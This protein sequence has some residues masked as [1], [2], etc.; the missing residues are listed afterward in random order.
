MGKELCLRLQ[1]LDTPGSSHSSLEHEEVKHRIKKALSQQF[2][3]GL[4]MAL[5]VLRA[6]IPFC[7]E[8]NQYTVKLAE[9]LLGPTWNDFTTVIFTHG[10]KLSETCMKEDEYLMSAP[11]KLLTLLE[12]VHKKYIFRDPSDKSLQKERAIL[13]SQMFDYVKNNKYQ[14]LHFD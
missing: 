14:S 8:D 9:E 10:D 7:E 12:K 2:P 3:G 11:K 1:V 6:D 13:T 5:L 4:H